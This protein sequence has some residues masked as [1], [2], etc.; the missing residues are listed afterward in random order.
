MNLD[1]IFA[2]IFF[3]PSGSV[4]FQLHFTQ[5]ITFPERK[6]LKLYQMF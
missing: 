4:M 2:T 5:K 6:M 3:N 1:D